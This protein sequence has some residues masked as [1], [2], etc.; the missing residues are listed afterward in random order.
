M[1]LSPEAQAKVN[2]QLFLALY[3]CSVEAVKKALAAGANPSAKD[4]LG[5]GRPALAEAIISGKR[6]VVQLLIN[7]G[8]DVHAKDDYQGM[9][10]LTYAANRG[11][12]D[13]V[14]DLIEAGVHPDETNANGFTPLMYAAVNE[15]TRMID[16]LVAYG[17]DVNKTDNDGR[18]ALMHMAEYGNI[19]A[20]KKLLEHK[21]ELNM[22]DKR[23]STA[24]KYALENGNEEIIRVLVRAGADVNICYQSACATAPKTLLLLL[25][26]DADNYDRETV[27]LLAAQDYSELKKTHPEVFKAQQKLIDNWTR[28]SSRNAKALRKAQKQMRSKVTLSGKTGVSAAL[29]QM[30]AVK[31]CSEELFIEPQRNLI[32]K[33]ISRYV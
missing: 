31:M 25:G 14:G 4:D 3:P 30:G 9:N 17:A 32:G 23:G 2:R 24:I 6:S 5:M 12:T 22:T 18:T 21:V 8:A 1:K 10:V 33:C 28:K 15:A 7:A 27:A 13:I 26:N 29:T 20:V 19:E 16:V 11:L